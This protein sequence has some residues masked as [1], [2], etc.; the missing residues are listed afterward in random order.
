[1]SDRWDIAIVGATGAVGES[2]L[3]ILS[4]R[5]FPVGAV[6]ALASERSVGKTVAFGNKQL[7]VENLAEFDFSKVAIGLF[8]AG[9][10]VSA[11]FAPKAAAAGCVVID[12]TSHF[13]RDDDIPLIV[14]EV[15]ADA[16]AG[17]TARGIIANPNC[18]TIQ[19]LVALKP[20]YDAVGIERINVCTYQAVSGAGRSA[21][22][23][24][25]RQTANLM[26]GRPLEIE[27][28]VK[29][30]AFNAIPHI[31]VFMDNR[32]TREEMK[33]VW[34]THKILGDDAILVNPTAVRIPV[35]YGHSEAVH[36]E[37]RDKIS[38]Q[39]VVEL[40]TKSP[41]IKVL[42]GVETGRYPTAVTEASGTDPVFV[43][44]IRED[45][46]HPRGIDLWVVADNI[47]KGAA[48]NSVQIAEI[49]AK[50]YL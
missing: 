39:S 49:L 50:N 15:N 48:L 24:L 9:G 26:N 12:N 23:E 41:G 22:E 20:I 43:G 17:Y 25:V 30:I 16:I 7:T 47:R 3:E 45:I 32:Y 46:S 4:A 10:S 8:S 31:D 13:R 21:I 38:A 19:M 2:M 33:M 5:K 14:P 42:D 37:T 6:Y 35:F 29:Q 36:I 27:G 34:E 40:L 44:R 18:S 1:M 28:D 11:E